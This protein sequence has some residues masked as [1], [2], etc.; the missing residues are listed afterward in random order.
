MIDTA[1]QLLREWPPGYGGVE[2]VVH[3]LASIWGGTVYSFDVQARSK[4]EH[5]ALPVGYGRRVLPCSFS[6]G[7]M[8][9][10]LPSRGLWSMVWSRRPLHGHLPSPGVLLA[11]LLARVVHPRRWVSAHWHSFLEPGPGL[12]GRMFVV[13]QSLVLRLLPWFSAV[14][15][16]SPVLAQELV[17]CGC[18]QQQVQVLPCCLSEEQ[19]C[20]ALAIPARR[21]QQGDPLRLIFIGRLDSYKRLDWLLRSLA[22]LKAPWQ[23]AVLGDGPRR[24]AFEA[25]SLSLF[26]PQAPVRFYGRVDE[27]SKLAQLALADLLVLP[28]DRCNEAFGIVQLEAMAAGI[29]ALAFQRH[30]SGM[31]WV[32]QLPALVWKQ[33]PEALPA[34]LERLASDRALL[35]QLGTQSRERYQQLFARQIWMHRLHELLP[36]S[37]ERKVSGR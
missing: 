27:A 7:R 26:G 14:V 10:P 9:I 30:R 37:A 20:Q 33:T 6:M 29:P 13:Y 28:S 17:R 2:R 12:E 36:H 19:E 5:D 15:T 21:M 11:L 34:V 25:L 35:S 18:R 31:G 4:H 22:A 23:L 24:Q 3:E 16:T 8:V 1:D 32:A